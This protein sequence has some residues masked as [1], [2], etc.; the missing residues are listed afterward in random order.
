M[1]YSR[2]GKLFLV[3]DGKAT[4]LWD[5]ATMQP[6][7]QPIVTPNQF[8]AGSSPDMSIVLT[9]G[10]GDHRSQLW[11]AVTGRP[12]G[13]PLV[14]PTGGPTGMVGDAAYSP[15]GKTIATADFNLTDSWRHGIRQQHRTI[16]A[17][18]VD[19]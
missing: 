17:S 3:R 12:I 2:D 5:K 10:G 6:I 19:G 4:R 13:P 7:G 16:V 14:H 1:A 18:S 8:C 11:D 9:T 15:D